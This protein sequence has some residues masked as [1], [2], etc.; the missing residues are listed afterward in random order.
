MEKIKVNPLQEREYKNKNHT[1]DEK[2]C[3]NNQ[4]K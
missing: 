4:I 1:N 2:Q 3:E